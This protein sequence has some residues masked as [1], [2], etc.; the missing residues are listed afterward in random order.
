MKQSILDKLENISERYTEVAAL[1]SEPDIIGNQNKFRDLSKEYAELEELL[2][3]TASE[4][5]DII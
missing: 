2:A 3:I 5:N 4:P 1:L